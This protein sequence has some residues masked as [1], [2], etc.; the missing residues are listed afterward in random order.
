MMRSSFPSPSSSSYF[1]SFP[2]LPLLGFASRDGSKLTTGGRCSSLDPFL[3]VPGP[4]DGPW[5]VEDDEN[6]Q[7]AKKRFKLHYLCR[8]LSGKRRPQ[9]SGDLPW[10]RFFIPSR[11]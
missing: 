10:D 5:N 1:S 11:F 8:S 3:T 2:P 6:P 4:E 9:R 7:T